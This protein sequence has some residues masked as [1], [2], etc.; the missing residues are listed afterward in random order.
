MIWILT[1]LHFTQ[2]QGNKPAGGRF[3]G[4]DI[5]GDDQADDGGDDDATETVTSAKKNKKEKKKQQAETAAELTETDKTERTGDDNDTGHKN[6]DNLL[7]TNDSEILDELSVTA[8]KKSK[9][10]KKDKRD[11]DFEDDSE[12]EK[13]KPAKKP[14]TAAQ[15]VEE[16]PDDESGAVMKTAAQKR[17]EKKEREKKKKEAERAKAKSK[18]KKEE[19]KVDTNEGDKTEEGLIE[20]ELP[21]DKGKQ[22]VAASSLSGMIYW[23]FLLKG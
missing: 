5:E 7:E 15:K 8:S 11:F 21:A 20:T 18:G 6:G 16:V 17:A 14:D 4:L 9:K 10:K 2:T 3:Q 23:W 1:C 13:V 19:T 12:D 22:D